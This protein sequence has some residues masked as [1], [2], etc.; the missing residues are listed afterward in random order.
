MRRRRGLI[1][2][3]GAMG[4]M[5][6]LQLLALAL[7]R[8][9]DEAGYEAVEDP[10]NPLYAAL[11]VVVILVATGA[12]LLAFRHNLQRFIRGAIIAIAGLLTWYVAAAL[13]PGIGLVAVGGV[14]LDVLSLGVAIGVMAA[15]IYHPEWYVIDIAAILIGA[16]AAALFGISFSILPI[17]LLLVVLAVYDAISV[18]GTKHMLTLAEGAM[19]MRLPVLLIIPMS[20]N[21]T[22][23][24]MEDGLPAEP[25]E[26]V[27]DQPAPDADGEA[28]GATGMDAIF[29]GLGDLVIPS[30]LVIAAAGQ[31]LGDAIITF[32]GVGLGF[33]VLGAMLGSL[34]GLAIL[35]AMVLRG[36]AH[37]G[38]PLLNGG[39]IL[40]YLLGALAAGIGLTTAVGF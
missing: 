30:I 4:L 6:V 34:V 25:P 31:G 38:L 11:F 26:D 23:R 20:W 12:M 7:L 5:F 17:I 32:G 8:P 21:F 40:G 27:D 2:S 1:A 36:R 15:L 19:S 22:T 3:V 37:A 33:E 29:L 35:M 13:T 10:A 14:L 9:F 16:G 28:G 24:E 18:Y 39:V